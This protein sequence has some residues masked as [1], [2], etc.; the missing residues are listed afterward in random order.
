MSYRI[1]IGSIGTC[2]IC[3]L[4]QSSEP[5]PGIYIFACRSLEDILLHLYSVINSLRA[6]G[7]GSGHF[8]LD[9]QLTGSRL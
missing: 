4:S 7:L 8:S 3:K 6:G 5:A 9:R 2:R 1:I